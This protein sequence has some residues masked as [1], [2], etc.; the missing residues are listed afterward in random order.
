MSS[1]KYLTLLRMNAWRRALWLVPTYL[2]RITSAQNSSITY[3]I[4][5]EV[6]TTWFHLSLTWKNRQL[7]VWECWQTTWKT[8]MKKQGDLSMSSL[9]ISMLD[10]YSRLSQMVPTVHKATFSL[11][12][13]PGLR[14]WSLFPE[15][16]ICTT[17]ACCLTPRQVTCA[18]CSWQTLIFCMRITRD[19]MTSS[20][21]R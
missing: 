3:S 15:Q 9:S 4:R 11:S 7:T 12:I 14:R 13:N 2:A 1:M 21:F 19:A 16:I 6:S 17:P 8:S 18:L 20:K 10:S 5:E